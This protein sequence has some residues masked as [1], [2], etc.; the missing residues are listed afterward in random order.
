M[1]QRY[2]VAA[3]LGGIVTFGLFF[4]MQALIAI[5]DARVDKS[6]R[7][8]VIDFVRLKK[9]QDLQTKD[10][11]KPEKE[12]QE[13]APPPPPLST[14]KAKPD[15]NAQG[16]Q[17]DFNM[18]TN[19]KGSEM[20]IGQGAVDSDSIPLVRIDP[21][22]PERAKERG[23]EGWVEVKFTISPRGTIEDPVVTSYHPSS[24]FNNSAI[25]AVRRWKYN[26]KIVNGKPV[27]RTEKVHL[28]FK[29]DNG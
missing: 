9:D 17:S 14:A 18:N 24:I 3:V 26:P 4:I 2:L 27:P 15:S 19:I 8:K 12:K 28:V 11:K 22:Y 21:T 5:G 13:E 16:I 10:K 20:S 25:R 23:I 1:I 6:D 7:G 29:L